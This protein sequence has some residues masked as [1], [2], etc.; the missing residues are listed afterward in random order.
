VPT[1]DQVQA[2]TECVEFAAH[3]GHLPNVQ[4]ALRL[5]QEAAA[6]EYGRL[7]RSV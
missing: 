3:Y 6:A 4:Q 2:R 7:A 5:A 1:F